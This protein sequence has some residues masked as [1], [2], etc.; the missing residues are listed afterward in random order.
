MHNK[1]SYKDG[2]GGCVRC[3]CLDIFKEEL[4]WA[5]DKR[6][7]VISN[8]MLIKTVSYTTKKLNNKAI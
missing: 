6:P 7:Y 4:T 8:M 1:M 2:S 3:T 5:T